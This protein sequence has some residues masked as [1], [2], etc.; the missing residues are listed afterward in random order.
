[1]RLLVNGKETEIEDKTTLE[2]L[3]GKFQIT[4]ESTGVAVA[5]NDVVVPRKAWGNTALHAGDRIE[6]IRAVQGG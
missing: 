3:L 4:K 1:M 6:I 5:V 2:K